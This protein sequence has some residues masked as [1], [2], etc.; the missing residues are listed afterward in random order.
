[1]RNAKCLLS[2]VVL[3]CCLQSAD[4]AAPAERPGSSP[5]EPGDSAGITRTI[6][7][8]R[9]FRRFPDLVAYR[10]TSIQKAPAPALAELSER[11]FGKAKVTRCWLN[12]DEMWDYRTRQYDYNY[13]IGV[14]KYDDLPEKFRESWG[15]VTE[16]RVHFHD[17]LKAFG[18][19]SDEVLLCIRRYERDILDGKLGVTMKDWKTIF[20]NAVK[21]SKQVCPN[22]R[23]IEVCNEYGCSGFI[24]CTADE[25]YRFY[26]LAYQAAN[27]VNEELKLTGEDRVLVGGP[28]VVRNA[29][30]ALNHFFENFSRDN[31][32]DKRLDFVT[33]HEYHNRYAATA[34]RQ[35][36]VGHMLALNGLPKNLPMFITEHD[37]YHPKAGST[38][39]NLINGAALVKSLYFTSL[40]S[41]GV[42]IMPWVQYHDGKIQTRFMWFEGPNEPDTKADEL[43]ML[44]AG[45]SMKFLSMHKDWEIAVDNDVDNDQIVLASVQNSGLVVQAVNYGP[46]RNVRLRIEKLP[47]VFSALG[48]G[49]VRVVKYLIDQEHSNCVANPDYPG[50]IEKVGDRR[51]EPAGGSITLE[52]P[53]LSKNGII[54][55]ELTPEKTGPVLNSPV[56]LAPAAPESK[57]P[58]FNAA[59]AMKNA[60]ATPDARIQRH[61]SAVLVHVGR[62]NSRPGV[63]FRPRTGGWDMTGPGHIEARVKNVGKRTLNVHLALD[64]PGANR[65]ERKGC[66]IKSATVPPGKEQKLTLA[67]PAQAP[68]ILKTAFRGM[69]GAPGGFSG[70]Q[71]RGIDPTNVVRISVYVYHP[72]AD[73]EYEVTDLCTGGAPA[74]PLPKD[75]AGLFP[76]IDRFGQYIHKDWPGK[77][78]SED[79][80]TRHRKQETVDLAAHPGPK[81]WNQYCGW[82]GGPKL[83][84]TGRFR[85]AK[86]CDKWWF[87]DPEGRLFWSHG[88]VRVTWSCGYTPITGRRFLFADLPTRD[89]PFGPFYGRSTWAIAGLYERGAETYNFTGA[90]L[91]RKYGPTWPEVFTDV[92]HRRLRSWGLNTLANCSQP[93]IYLKRKTPYTATV[94]SLDSP[95]ADT[96][97]GT[98]YVATIHD[99]SRVIEDAGG[100]WGKFPDVFDPSFKATL[101]KEVAQHKGKAVGDPWCLGYFLGNELTWGRDETWLARAV[102][103]SPA[104]QPAKKVLA[105]DLKKKYRDINKLNAAWGTDY[106]SWNAL[107][108]STTPPGGKQARGDLAAFL[109]KTADA[110]FRQC[111]EA[112]KEVD[113]EGL[114]LGC[115]FAGWANQRIFLAAAKYSDVI[116][117]NRYAE[118]VADLR[119]PGGV[120]K[121][122]VIGEFHFG[123]L[124]RGK[125]HASLRPVADQQARGAA[126]EKYVRSA[127]ENPAVVGTHWHQYGDQATT[128]RDDGENFQ[129]GFIDVCDTPY[130][131]TIEACRRIGH[132]LYKVRTGQDGRPPNRETN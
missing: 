106:A 33:W 29:M 124:D 17:Y 12:L 92:T 70:R 21:R 78:H 73:Y 86:W 126:Y 119:L 26:R 41:P 50:G 99:D 28:N 25:Y 102:L 52:H 45:C 109:D 27:E 62:S 94:Y 105:D 84:A 24:G 93:A 10:N 8:S 113:P 121:P 103:K 39:Y 112:V 74:F 14:H 125:F 90:N 79:D 36:E 22:L 83:E 20:K 65:T 68:R 60:V 82:L 115:R 64:N 130:T 38:E 19:H 120:D 35:E 89:S 81:D 76:M 96:P 34:G 15:W 51:V 4:G 107:L 98:G 59:E 5:V 128:G 123:S 114:Y 61:G 122:A 129:N 118:S 116:S 55:W 75:P 18:R 2:L 43:R 85:V 16:T 131:E 100:G 108:K 58:P 97:G 56:S 80:L 30:V 111:R 95:P 44:P 72:G 7:A 9:Y 23:Y 42:K 63:T 49:K 132:R 47:A 71:G 77:I 104:R 101:L 48:S 54:L 3:F 13:R 67:I 1:M 69:R 66:V 40:H 117:V 91:L 88:L 31:S 57:Q 32:P 37:P 53:G 110:Y 127:L 87:V 46:P 11:E 6:D